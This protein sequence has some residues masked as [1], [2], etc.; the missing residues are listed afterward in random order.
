MTWNPNCTVTVDGVDYSSKTINSVSVT[1]GRTSYWEQA[2]TG[3]STVEIVNWDDTDYAFEINDDLVITVDNASATPRTVFTGKVTNIA[4]RMVAVGT[5][6]E[7]AVITLTAVGPF[8]AMSRKIIGTSAYSKELDSD[9]MSQIFT[10]AG[11]TVDVVDTPGIYEFTSSAANPL[12]A[13]ASAAKYASMAN[14]YI[15]ETADGKV[16][17]AN[18]SRRTIDVT[19][20]GYMEI[21][22]DYILWRSV[23]SNK[24]LGDILNE[25]RLSYKA[26]A[27]VTASDATSQGLYGLLGAQINTE[28]EL[29][30]EAQELA[31]KYVALRRVPRLN[32]SSFTIQLDSPNV[33]SADLDDLLQMTMGKAIEINNL[34]IPL[35]PT[36]YYGFVEGWILQV[37]RNQAVISLTTSESS[38]S[39]QPTRWQDV[40]AALAWNAVGAAVQWATYD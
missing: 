23:S 12:D 37:S 33:S 29:M 39:I 20:S 22:E 9:R 6:E 21:P 17:F 8:A 35:I 30:S 27:V 11:V 14:G 16:G 32:M 10:D 19:A 36:N 38:Y 15:Y 7:V 5:V 1:Y 18:E 40:D 26:N 2:R 24:S 3:Y 13:Y 4:S 25:I 34:P 31:D 28:L